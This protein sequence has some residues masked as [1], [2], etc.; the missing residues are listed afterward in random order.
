MKTR[1][2]PLALC[3]LGALGIGALVYLYFHSPYEQTVTICPIYQLTG[4]RCPGCGMTRALYCLLHLDLQGVFREN[5]F[6][7]VLPFA[8][9]LA[10]TELLPLCGVPWRL[11]KPRLSVPWMLALLAVWVVYGFGRNFF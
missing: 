5:P 2:L 7:F 9:Y 1:L 8:G 6:L 3:V 10:L 11:P 4:L